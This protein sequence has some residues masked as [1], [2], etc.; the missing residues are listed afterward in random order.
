[1]ENL[2]IFAVFY[3]IFGLLDKFLKGSKKKQK[4]ITRPPASQSPKQQAKPK[5]DVEDIPPFLRKLLGM[6][7]AE[8]TKKPKTSPAAIPPTKSKKV[9]SQEDYLPEDY[10]SSYKTDIRTHAADVGSFDEEP[11]TIKPKKSLLIEKPKKKNKYGLD[12]KFLRNNAELKKAILLKEIFDRPI[13]LR[14]P[15]SPYMDFFVK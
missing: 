3:I 8:K 14:G 5:R 9:V 1:M 4:P 15:R 11:V 13:S 10:T 12:K 2:I 7:P 6:E